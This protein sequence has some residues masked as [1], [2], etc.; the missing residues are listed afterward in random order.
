MAIKEVCTCDRCGKEVLLEQL[1]TLTIYRVA[2]R[3]QSGCPNVH[4]ADYCDACI[5]MMGIEIVDGNI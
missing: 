4:K 1:Y 3:Y 2:D 5:M